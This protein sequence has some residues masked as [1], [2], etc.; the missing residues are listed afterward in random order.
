MFQNG[1]KDQEVIFT[2]VFTLLGELEGVKMK[3]FGGGKQQDS[4]IE[5][6][7]VCLGKELGK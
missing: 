6:Q 1:F 7:V 3:P 4:V 5:I 2:S